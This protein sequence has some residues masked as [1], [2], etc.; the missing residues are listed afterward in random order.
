MMFAIG[1]SLEQCHAKLKNM[2]EC[3]GGSFEQSLTH[4]SPFKLSKMVLMNLPRS[5]RDPIPGTLSL[6]K[7]NLDGSVSTSLLY[8][9]SSFKYLGIIF[10]PKLCWTLQQTKVLTTV[11]FWASHI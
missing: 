10:N 9:V 4:H 1:D 11:T 3:V 8:S 5:Y 7:L 6:A 2:M